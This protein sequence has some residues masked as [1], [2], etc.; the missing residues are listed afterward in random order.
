MIKSYFSL[1]QINLAKEHI[2]NQNDKV[3]YN[4]THMWPF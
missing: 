2:K 4:K 1:I 3:N